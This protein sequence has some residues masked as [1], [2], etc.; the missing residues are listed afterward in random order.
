MT[1]GV[2]TLNGSTNILVTNEEAGELNVA[3]KSENKGT[4]EVKGILSFK[5]N[6]VVSNTGIINLYYTA[7]LT[8]V[9]GQVATLNN[10]N[11]INYYYAKS[12]DKKNVNI[13]NVEDGQFIAEYN[14]GIVP[15]TGDNEKKADFM[16]NANSYGVTHYI[17]SKA[18]D[19]NS[20]AWSLTNATKITVKKGVTLT[21]NPTKASTMGLTASKALLYFEGNNELASTG[22]YASY[23]KVAV[24]DITLAYGI[25]LT[26]NVEVVLTGKFQ[27]EVDNNNS[28]TYTVDNKGYIYGGIRVSQSGTITW[29]GKEYGVKK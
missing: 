10:S 18:S 27:G 1:T 13:T 17:I 23:A 21:F 15:G 4:M 14:D 8:G 7:Q 20:E 9:T 28:T 22:D 16:K 6:A 3:N 11:V 19:A 24:K 2:A 25:K 26:N 29:L 12:G 5:G